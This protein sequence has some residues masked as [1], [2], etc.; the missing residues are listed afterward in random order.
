MMEHGSR[1]SGLNGF[2]GAP[3]QWRKTLG[4]PAARLRQTLLRA[5][6][7]QISP[8][9]P[10]HRHTARLPKPIFALQVKKKIPSRPYRSAPN[11]RIPQSGIYNKVTVL[12]FEY[13]LSYNSDIEQR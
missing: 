11:L 2:C 5:F 7:G 12:R 13:A 4:L 10:F 6:A 1:N 3:I 8:V 9:W